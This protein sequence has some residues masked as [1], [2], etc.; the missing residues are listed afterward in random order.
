MALTGPGGKPFGG[1]VEPGGT[2]QGRYVFAVP[3][4]ERDRVQ[5]TA[6]YIGEAPDVVF[7]GSA[8]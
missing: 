6:S 1:E 2:A 3:A 5:I 7:T 4:A 8:R